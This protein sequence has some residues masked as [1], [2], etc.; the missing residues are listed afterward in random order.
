MG[1]RQEEEHIILKMGGGKKNAKDFNQSHSNKGKSQPN[2]NSGNEKREPATAPYNFVPLN[3]KVVSAQ[4]LDNM[5]SDQLNTG[6]IV[7]NLT[8]LSPLFI[9]MGKENADKSLCTKFFSP[10]E[11][12]RIPGSSIRGAV[13]NLFEVITHGNFKTYN[14]D[15]LYFRSLME[16]GSLTREYQNF[17]LSESINKTSKYLVNVGV[18]TQ[19]GKTFEIDPNYVLSQLRLTEIDKI[20]SSNKIKEFQSIFIEPDYYLKGGKMFNTINGWK[21]AKGQTNYPSKPLSEDDVNFYENDRNRTEKYPNL[22]EEA[23]RNKKVPVFYVERNGNIIIGNTAMMRV[24]YN[25]TIPGH[26]PTN[27]NSSSPDLAETVFGAFLEGKESDP[28]PSRVFFEDCF[29]T[30]TAEEEKESFAKALQGP[31]AT[32]YQ[33][34]LVQPN[35][36]NTGLSQ[37][38]TYN[39]DANIRGYKQYWHKKD[40]YEWKQPS[41][42]IKNEKMYPKI[43]PLKKGATFKGRIYFENLTD[44][45]LGALLSAVDLPPDYAHKIGM[46]K[47]IGLGSA[48]ITPTLYLFGKDSHTNLGDKA[49]QVEESNKMKIMTQFRN[50][51]S[52]KIGEQADA[53]IWE[54]DR[55]K[56]LGKMLDLKNAPE[57]SKTEYQELEK[58]RDRKV[59]PKINEV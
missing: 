6:Y 22:I 26:I 55:L 19:K 51:L 45:E 20:C 12:F 16:D 17:K 42:N 32:S 54:I 47:P 1:R 56:Q 57:N 21:I 48:R 34:Y 29:V 59:L 8:A 46:G 11:K 9:G 33:L 7:Y 40:G 39:S 53:S 49:I 43:T 18:L 3:T 28:I 14:N 35:G 44:I 58:F 50:Y 38:K 5:S 41:S 13:R 23:R 4:Y 52:E 37:L 24:P 2:H 25:K 15:H 36:V 31:K 30:S 27:L 10:G